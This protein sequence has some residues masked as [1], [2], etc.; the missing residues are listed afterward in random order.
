MNK[1]E[2]ITSIVNKTGL[3]VKDTE[4][5]LKALTEVVTEKLVKGEKVQLVGFG[6]FEVT[7]RAAREGRNPKTGEKLHIE[8]SKVPKFKAGKA[9]K[10]AVK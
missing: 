8:A 4:A 9:L 5:F 6:T 10:D 1:P 2:L 7:E 3:Q